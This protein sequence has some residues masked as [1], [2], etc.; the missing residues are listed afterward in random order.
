M[1]VV[2]AGE[3]MIEISI[4]APGRQVGF[5]GDTFNTAVYLARALPPGTVDYATV[6]G[7]DAHPVRIGERGIE[8]PAQ[9]LG[10][11]Q[12]DGHLGDGGRVARPGPVV[13]V[14][15]GEPEDDHHRE[16][17][18]EQDQ[19][20]EDAC[21]ARRPRTPRPRPPRVSGSM[22]V[23]PRSGWFAPAGPTVPGHRAGSED[24]SEVR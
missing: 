12:L 13:P 11:R 16:D 3:A 10:E 4:D 21:P 5:A 24:A 22:P 6:V 8:L 18:G 19:P 15:A 9:A 23:G 1:K 14:P 2:C 7:R 17:P 20:A